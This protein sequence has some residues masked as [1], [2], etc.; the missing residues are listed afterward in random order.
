MGTP[1]GK[2]W[3]PTASNEAPRHFG[4]P[5]LWESFTEADMVALQLETQREAGQGDAEAMVELGGINKAA[6]TDGE[7]K[8]AAAK[9][10]EQ[11]QEEKRPQ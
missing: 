6:L 4:V 3:R 5:V 9:T 1:Q 2:A 11:V 10:P 8:P 7:N